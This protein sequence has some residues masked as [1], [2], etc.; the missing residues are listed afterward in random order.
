MGKNTTRYIAYVRKS[1][2]RE[3]RQELSHKAQE[4]KIKEQFGNLKIVRW[5]EPESKSAFKPGRPVFK[6]MIAMIK[7]GKADGIVSYHPNRLS[8]NEIDAATLTYMLR[9]KELLD[10]KFCS[11]TF[12]NSPEGIMMLQLM[13]SQSQY[14]SSKQGRDVQRGM[15]QK[16]IGGERPGVV[17][18]G[19]I[20]APRKDSDG[21][22]LVDPKDKTVLTKT[23]DDP[24]RYEMVY[25]MWRMLLSGSYNASQIRKIA[26]E[27]W[28]FK[29]RTTKRLNGKPMGY[30]TIYRIF[31][32]PFYAGL[33]SHNGKQYPGNHNAMITIEEFDYAQKLLGAKG[34]PRAGV[35]SYAYT[36]LI[37]CGECGCQI[38][39][40]TNEKFVKREGRIK[41]YVHYYC[42][43]KSINRPCNQNKYTSLEALELEIDT[44]L[45]RVTI[46]PAFR[47]LA[48]EI[49]RRKHREETASQAIMHRSKNKLKEEYQ[50]KLNN[51]VDMRLKDLL[52]DEEYAV[53]KE[54][55]IKELSKIEEAI[56][57]NN[58]RSSNWLE[59]TEQ[60]FDFITKARELFKTGDAITKRKVFLAL[61]QNFTLKDQKLHIEQSPWLV[62]IAENYPDIEA[63]YLKRV[64][65][66]KKASSKVKE[67]A[68]LSVSETWRA[69]RDLNPGHP[70]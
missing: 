49:V 67:E 18:L 43:R 15:E 5:M 69:S 56:S 50:A 66:N 45:S 64:A 37:K 8:R 11:Y 39:G 38:V 59:S 12:E 51:L 33:I 6:E 10:L 29:T 68:F 24:E 44:L 4:R 34:K 53:Q 47:D 57:D 26:N 28:G 2:E 23:E 17:S 30:S 22:V 3:E 31:T 32:N 63:E 9:T 36:G 46:L 70:A 41:T 7:A 16:V 40:K 62:P 20:K 61:G 48:L 54:R 21:N 42:T 14:E 13:M 1:E 35:N 58:I 25:K 65:T 52:N 27:E 19:Y 60:A 55:Y